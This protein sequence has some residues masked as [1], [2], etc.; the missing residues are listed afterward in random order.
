MTTGWRLS[1]PSI[2]FELLMYFH[3][4][5]VDISAYSYGNLLTGYQKN[6]KL[7][8]LTGAES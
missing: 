5:E 7:C 4:T 2:Y 8:G 3:S 1:R 6:F